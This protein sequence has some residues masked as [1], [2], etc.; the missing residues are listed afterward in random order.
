[1]LELIFISISAFMAGTFSGKFLA[2]KGITAD[3]ALENHQK[4]LI[5]IV[6]GIGLIIVFLLI[7]DK[8]DL[9][10]L[11]PKVFPSIILLYFA[12]YF[13]QIL[14]GFGCFTCGLI[15]LLELSGKRSP[16]R[17]YQLIISLGAIACAL[18]ILLIFLRPVDPL[19]GTPK[20]ID[21]VVWQTTSY[22][23]APSSIA[24]LGRYSQKSPNSTEREVVQL[25]KTNRFG[26]TTLAE[27]K[28]MKKLGLQP[29]YEHNLS[30]KDLAE[31]N[32]FALLHVKEKNPR[33]GHKFSHAVALLLIDPDEQLVVIGNPLF[34]IQ[35]K[36]FASMENYWLGEAILVNS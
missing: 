19:L 13:H 9:A 6:S 15:L 23:C 34:G 27:I 14:I 18:S 24:T 20:I 3:N 28:A 2:T 21:G 11:L 29:E 5:W 7:I 31:L 36:T 8:F 33:N 35:V 30:L 32:K 12:G 25:T 4:P 22:T 1:M 10:P 26:T 16:Q 17:I